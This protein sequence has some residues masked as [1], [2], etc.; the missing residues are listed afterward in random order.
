ML[1][2]HK[3]NTF[4]IGLFLAQFCCKTSDHTGRVSVWASWLAQNTLQ[5]GSSEFSLAEKT[6]EQI[7]R[8]AVFPP[9]CLVTYKANWQNLVKT[10]G[11]LSVTHAN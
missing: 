5:K 7:L 2:I 1:G 8:V 10:Q 4:Y 9:P 11:R 3:F 6:N